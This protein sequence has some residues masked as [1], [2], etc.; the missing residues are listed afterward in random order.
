MTFLW[1]R[2]VFPKVFG[3]VFGIMLATKAAQAGNVSDAISAAR[4]AALITTGVRGQINKAKSHYAN[5]FVDYLKKSDIHNEVFALGVAARVARD[6]R[7]D[8]VYKNNAFSITPN[9]MTVRI[10]F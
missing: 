10:P 9:S 6:K 8:F 4:E 5:E 2:K 7:I 1:S 3:G